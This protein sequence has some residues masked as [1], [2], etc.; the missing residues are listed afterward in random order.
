MLKKLVD[1]KIEQ[2]K[3]DFPEYGISKKTGSFYARVGVQKIPRNVRNSGFA[4]TKGTV[5]KLGTMN[6]W[7]ENRAESIYLLTQKGKLMVSKRGARY[8][9]VSLKDLRMG[10]ED[11]KN[12][13]FIGRKY[14][15]MREFPN[16]YPYR[17]FQ[18]FNSLS[19]A[20]KFLGYSFISDSDFVSLFGDKMFDYLMPIILAEEK[21][22]AA[23]L[24]KKINGKSLDLLSDYLNMCLN[25]DIPVK[26]PAG[27][28][29]L[30]ELHSEVTLEINR[31]QMEL[32]SKEFR[33]EITEEFTKVWRERGLVFKRL[34]TPYEMF[35]VGLKQSHCIGTNYASSL[36]RQAFYSFTYD[37]KQWEVLIYLNGSVGQ[38]YGKR[39]SEVPYNL[40]KLVTE[41]IDLKFF[42]TDVNPDIEDYPYKMD[43]SDSTSVNDDLWF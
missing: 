31:T 40:R 41:D 29:R 9:N 13:F 28:N 32:Y 11:L 42:L 4:V 16:L 27:I 37:S 23:S 33:Y 5:G 18:S 34:E 26:I 43:K 6:T 20:K 21:S 12:V 8:K 35:E 36:G 22:N 10:C 14:E 24:M 17:F 30:D 15:W 2:F 25:N 19:D 1:K 3:K 39:N 7:V 38:F